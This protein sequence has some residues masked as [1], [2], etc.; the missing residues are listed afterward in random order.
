MSDKILQAYSLIRSG[1]PSQAK[2][3]LNGALVYELENQEILFTIDCCN[4]WI[5][6][7]DRA[8]GLDDDFERGQ[9]Y[10]NEWKKNAASFA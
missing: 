7:M 3:L 10:C 5:D 1:N 8:G 9:S 4:F 6:V 2:D